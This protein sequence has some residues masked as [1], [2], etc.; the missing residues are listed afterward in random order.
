MPP[1]LSL[2]LSISPS[3]CL[4]LFLSASLSLS[5][6]LFHLFYSFEML[7]DI[8]YFADNDLFVPNCLNSEI[9]RKLY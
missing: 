4:C 7:D 1:N 3:L 6:F 8:L 9:V 5:P 2:P